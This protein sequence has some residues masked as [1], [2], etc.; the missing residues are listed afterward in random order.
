MGIDIKHNFQPL[1]L[2]SKDKTQ[3]IKDIRAQIKKVLLFGWRLTRIEKERQ[4][5]GIFWRLWNWMKK[6]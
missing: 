4:L 5:D 3:V 2:I 6:R 1:I